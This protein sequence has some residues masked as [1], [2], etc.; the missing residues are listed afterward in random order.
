MSKWMRCQSC[1]LVDI[2][3]LRRRQG[4]CRTSVVQ[5]QVWT[6]HIDRRR[7]CSNEAYSTFYHTGRVWMGMVF[8]RVF[9]VADTGILLE[10]L[11]LQH[12][13]RA[14]QEITLLCFAHVGARK[15]EF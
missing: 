8:F 4:S 9:L 11:M 7:R 1:G 14:Y 3:C 2:V 10:T 12:A 15:C 13:L 5:K 6:R